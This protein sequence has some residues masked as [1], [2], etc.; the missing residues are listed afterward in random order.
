MRQR[1]PNT[2]DLWLVFGMVA[3]IIYSIM[4]IA[5]FY[6]LPSYL[7]YLSM[8]DLLGVFAYLTVGALLE[9]LCLTAALIAIGVLFQQVRAS[10]VAYSGVLIVLWQAWAMLALTLLALMSERANLGWQVWA[11]IVLPLLLLSA[12]VFIRAPRFKKFF[13]AAA[14]RVLILLFLFLPMSAIGLIVIVIR[15]TTGGAQ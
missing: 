6:T 11:L 12:L 9:S 2:E 15:L 8:W 7:V 13:F 3:G 1:I 4:L 5:F 10:F 14:D